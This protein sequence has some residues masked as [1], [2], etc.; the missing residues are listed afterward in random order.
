MLLA[1]LQRE[2]VG[3]LAVGV[4]RD[5]DQASGQLPLERVADRDVTGVRTAEPQRHAEP[6]ARAHCDVRARLA[7]WPEQGQGQQ[8]G[9]HRRQ[10][11]LGVRG[12]DQRREVADGAG[13]PGELQQDAEQVRLRGDRL[14]RHR[15]HDELDAERLG[16]SAENGERLRQAVGIGQEHLAPLGGAARERHGLDG[17][18]S[19]VE[20]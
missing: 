5:P 20:Q 6:L 4:H 8:I 19:L 9:G 17:G 11:A 15:G 12:L 13:R 1:G 14:G 18:S 16:P 2:P 3:G 7:W 10:R